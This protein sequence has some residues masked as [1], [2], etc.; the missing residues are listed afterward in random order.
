MLIT[1]RNEQEL[2]TEIARLVMTGFTPVN[3]TPQ[4]AVLVKRKQFNVALGVLGFLFCVVGLAVYAIIFAMQKDQMIEIRIERGQS[5][6]FSADGR[7]WWDGDRWL[8]TEQ[9]VPLGMERSPDGRAW[10]DGQRWRPVPA[11]GGAMGELP[12][13]HHEGS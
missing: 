9:V 6:S 8:D 12:G 2:E 11:S 3:R 7:W 1:V 13:P 5:S 4:S 10:F